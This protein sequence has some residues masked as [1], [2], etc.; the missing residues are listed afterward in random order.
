MNR[1]D[2]PSLT[3][4][5][6][7]SAVDLIVAACQPRLILVFGSRARGNARPDSDLDLL[8][9][10]QSEVH[11]VVGLR[12]QLRSLLRKLPIAKDILVSGPEHFAFWSRH[13]NSVYRTA[14]E[15]GLLL[16]EEARLDKAVAARI[17]H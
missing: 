11:D 15:E 8:V 4:E 3:P 1:V 6:V 16:W 5:D 14:V 12:C 10:L 7:A 2:H 9:V 17:C 13:H